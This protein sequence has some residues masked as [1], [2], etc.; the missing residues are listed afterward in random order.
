MRYR[1]LGPVDVVSDDDPDGPAIFVG[2]PK[3]RTVLAVLIATAG[4][5]ASVDRLL[6]A[7]YGEDANPSNRAT[8]HTYVYNLRRA[9]GDVIVR[10]GDGYVLRSTGS[11][12]D[13]V[14]FEDA[15]AA[16][17]TSEEPDQEA[18]RL[19]AALSMWRGRPYADV[20]SH[21]FLDGEITRLNELRLTALEARIDADLRAGRHKD[22]VSELDAL[23]VEHPFRESLQS[24]HMLALYRCGRQGEALRAYG[25][26]RT[27]LVEG[28]GI[29]P[30]PEL[31]EMERRILVQDRTLL[32]S[33]GPTVKRRAIV[34]ADV[35]ER[36][37][38]AVAR[39][40]AF[41]RR[42]ADLDAATSEFGGV[43]LS[44]RGTARYAV[45]VEPIDAVRA[46]RVLVN[47]HT[48]V[49]IEYGDLESGDG[50]PIG[51]PLIRAARLVAV[52]NLGQAI[53]SS[54]AHEV[55]TRAGV[56]GWGA[57]SL[58][59]FE[60]VGLDGAVDL[61]QLVGE[62]FASDFPPLQ[63]DRLPPVWTRGSE[64]SIPGFELRSLIR[65]GEL[66]EVH[67][68]YQPSVGREV[69]VRIFG[70]GVVG[71]AR[72]LR[73]FESV[74]QRVTRVEHP[75]VVPLLDYWREPDRAVMV[76]RLMNGGHL[77]ERIPTEGFA[78]ADALAAFETVAAGVASAHRHGVVHGRLRP[79]NV[80]FDD[81]GN[82]YVADLGVDEICA[83]VTTFAST[84]YDAPERVGGTFATPAADIYSLGVLFQQ[85]LT[86]APPPVD[87]PLPTGRVGIDAVI[88]AAVDADPSARQRTV[89]SLVVELREALAVPVHRPPTALQAR[90]PYR[91]LEPFEQ[92]DASDFFGRERAVAEM[93]ELLETEHLLVVVGPS[94][95]GKSSV[96]KA[97]LVPALRRG[98]VTG[99]AG[100]LVTEMTPG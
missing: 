18:D 79:E 86:G 48:R 44:P 13:A 51:P 37:P 9:L 83:G 27:A 55:L 100:W 2:G 22:V 20:E 29:D 72:F 53:C 45:F 16:A 65:L 49:A 67:R 12:I 17:R 73:R 85:L 82:G 4:G 84:A 50:E 64:R 7:M 43:A 38:D 47:D 61:Y 23:T 81:E 26:T 92:A 19:S 98:T 93:T 90:N 33:V 75:A 99:S 36:W 59:R 56:S 70:A 14:E 40:V 3:Q 95:I 60:I 96:V 62:G 15:C 25:R 31:Q 78:P 11:T 58:G 68:A 63:L 52:A 10:Q 41:A 80:L 57:A 89:E 32:V 35:D 21:G 97:G 6:Q 77:G 5:T 71:D 87:R 24:L 88:A 69:A 30:S 28:L 74:S 54:T 34:V 42:D 39:D 8:L 94:G 66:G 76:S 1:V 91:G 46:A